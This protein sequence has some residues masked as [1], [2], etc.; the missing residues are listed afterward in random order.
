MTIKRIDTH[1]EQ[2]IIQNVSLGAWS[3]WHSVRR[4]QSEFPPVDAHTLSLFHL[5]LVLPI[6]FNKSAAEAIAGQQ[7]T[8]GAFH[9]AISNNPIVAVGLQ[10]RVEDMFSLSLRSLNVASAAG[11]VTAI[12]AIE[13]VSFT[14]GRKTPPSKDDFPVQAKSDV[15]TIFKCSQRLGF[16]F[17]STPIHELT[18]QL[19]VRF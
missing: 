16:W 1:F 9:R 2:G 18:S 14:L 5:L 10:E 19:K 6:A 15:D 17:A 4:F 12:H 11:L 7:M 3:L 13:G 8:A